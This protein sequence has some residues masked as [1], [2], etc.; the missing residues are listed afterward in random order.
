[1]GTVIEELSKKVSIETA[2]LHDKVLNGFLSR[3]NVRWSEDPKIVKD[4]LKKKGYELIID[5][6][7]R[8]NGDGHYHRIR[9][10][11][12]IDSIE[13]MIQATLISEIGGGEKHD[14]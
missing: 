10:V 3:N 12:T 11:K 14:I 6:V 4:R 9:L 7:N 5:N 2:I 8:T 13:Y 1:M